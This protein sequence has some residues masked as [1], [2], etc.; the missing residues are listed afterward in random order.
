MKSSTKKTAAPPVKVTKKKGAAAGNDTPGRHEQET[1]AEDPASA[2]AQG[3]AWD[4]PRMVVVVPPEQLKLSKEEL[5]AETTKMLT[6]NNPNAPTNIA[7]YSY[8]EKTFKFEPMV[9]QT[10]FHFIS[11]G[12]LMHKG[13]DEAKRQL[14]LDRQEE[15]SAREYEQVLLSPMSERP[16]DEDDSRQL[17]NQFNFSERAAQTQNNP[18]RDRATSMEPPPMQVYTGQSTQWDIYDAY[19]EDQ[20]RLAKQAE[21]NKPGIPGAK[22]GDGLLNGHLH[23]PPKPPTEKESLIHSAS[24]MKAAK[25]MERMVNQNSFDDIAQDYKYW[26]DASDAFREMEGT[27]LPLWKFYNERAKRKHVTALCWNPEYADLFAVGYGSFDFMKQGTG[28]ICCYSLKNPSHPEYTFTTESGVMC[29]HFHPQHSSLLA[30]GLYDGT[31]MVY[32]VRNKVNRPIF[33]STVKTGKHTDPVWQVVWQEDDLSKALNFFSVSSDGR[34]TLWIMSKSELQY[35]DVM[36][37]KLTSSLRELEPEDETTLGSLAGGCSFDFNRTSDHL[38]I[39]GTEEG[40]I[41]KCSKAYNSQYLETYKGH[42]MSVYAV[43]WNCWH[44]RVFLSCSADWTVKLWDHN[45][46]KPVMS[47]DLN[48]AVGDVAWYPNSSTTFAAVTNDGKVHVYDLNENKHEP[49]CEQKIV[50]KAKLTKIAFNPKSP[51]VLV[52]DDRGC[53]TSLKLSPNLR[54]FSMPDKTKSHQELETE[55]LDRILELALKGEGAI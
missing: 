22:S 30:V 31:V 29:L 32:D 24:M 13:T 4:V 42:H 45:L 38:F 16:D 6:A 36:E 55:K 37:L 18:R 9:D 27:L 1:K 21:R 46:V 51:I 14:E 40:R 2:A 11:D 15:I 25:V 8:K 23:D 17:R 41:H 5:V 54:K 26:E 12:W 28:L 53:V 34:V 49:M 50:H 47:F 7:R 3:D 52:G 20:E 35:Q 10:E 39:V 33:A 43:R 19:I 48:N 44:P